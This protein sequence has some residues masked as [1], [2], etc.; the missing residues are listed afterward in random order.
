M[1]NTKKLLENKKKYLESRRIGKFSR[2]YDNRSSDNQKG[3]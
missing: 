1:C 3:G 2:S